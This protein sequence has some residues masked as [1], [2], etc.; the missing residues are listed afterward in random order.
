MMIEAVDGWW[1]TPECA[2]VHREAD[3]R[4]EHLPLDHEK[5]HVVEALD[6]VELGEHRFLPVG[7]DRHRDDGVRRTSEPSHHAHA[8]GHEQPVAR[9]DRAAQIG[10]AQAPEPVEAHIGG[11]V[12]G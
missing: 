4:V 9:L 5:R 7:Q 8:L 11:V 10:V 12:D 2:A 1:L 3:H 6:T